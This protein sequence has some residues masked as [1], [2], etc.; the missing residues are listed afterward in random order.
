MNEFIEEGFNTELEKI[1]GIQH[2]VGEALIGGSL[3]ASLGA[4]TGKK[5][6]RLKRALV[7]GSI[8]AASSLGLAKILKNKAIKRR[9]NNPLD[10]S[11]YERWIKD[12]ERSLRSAQRDPSSSKDMIKGIKENL[13]SF[14]SSLARINKQNTA[15][16]I[17]KTINNRLF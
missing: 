12:T 10:T 8:G 2:R 17:K 3:G 5:E 15:E 11:T 13:E 7:G 14:K 16:H 4:L 9:M 1:S 6:N